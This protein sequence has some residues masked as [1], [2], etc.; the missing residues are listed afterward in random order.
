MESRIARP[1][2]GTNM[3]TRRSNFLATAFISVVS[4]YLASNANADQIYSFG[5]ID[6]TTNRSAPA[7]NNNGVVAFIEGTN[8]S[9]SAIVE[10]GSGGTPTIIGDGT[11]A[12][13]GVWINDSGQVAF[14]NNPSPGVTNAVRGSGGPLTVIGADILGLPAIDDSGNVTFSNGTFGIVGGLTT[15][16]IFSGN[17]G[18]LTT[19]L[20]TANS[21]VAQYPNK[22]ANFAVSHNGIIAY[23]QYPSSS[24]SSGQQ[25]ITTQSGVHKVIATVATNPE[26]GIS[27]LAVNNA[28]VVAIAGNLDFDDSGIFLGDG[29]T[30]TKAITSTTSFSVMGPASINDLDQLAFQANFTNGAAFDGI[31][32]G[33]D[34]VHDKVIQTGDALGGSI[35]TA[36]AFGND[37]LNN[38]GQV[39]FWAQLANGTSGV[40]VAT[41][42]PEPSFA[43]LSLLVVGSVFLLRPLNRTSRGAVGL[44]CQTGRFPRGLL[45][46]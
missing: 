24:A 9:T 34:P 28:G 29:K 40:Y 21:N 45:E 32:T 10:T 26:A 14:S 20:P 1:S 44:P 15:F 8:S 5:H 46:I 16:G 6:D 35:V 3:L 42:I 37:A 17:G 13:Q 23:Q 19:V 12:A 30:L 4:L 18:A 27:S 7:I 2:K 25:V 38:S 36:L 11:A 41:P 39:V 22:F 43:V 33:Q 31:Y